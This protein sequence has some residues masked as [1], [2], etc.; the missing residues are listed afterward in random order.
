MSLVTILAWS[1]LISSWTLA[2]RIENKEH[3]LVV[4][5]VLQC[6][7]FGLFLGALIKD[8]TIG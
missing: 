8:V 1:L 7:A 5:I 6:I 2:N 4:K 3:K